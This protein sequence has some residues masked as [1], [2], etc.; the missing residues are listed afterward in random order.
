MPTTFDSPGYWADRSLGDLLNRRDEVGQPVKVDPDEIFYR[1]M[2]GQQMWHSKGMP[3]QKRGTTEEYQRTMQ[4]A[5]PFWLNS[6]SVP[7]RMG[8]LP[9]AAGPGRGAQRPPSLADL[10]SPDML[11]RIQNSEK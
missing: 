3:D 7:T 5:L 11:A 8:E 2:P 1:F 6:R 9:S 4:E 10:Y